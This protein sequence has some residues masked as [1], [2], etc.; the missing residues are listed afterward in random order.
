MFACMFVCLFDI[1][2]SHR[3]GPQIFE[4]GCL[5]WVPG[6]SPECPGGV[7]GGSRGVPGGSRGGPEGSRVRL[8]LLG[9]VLIDFVAVLGP[10]GAGL[11]AWCIVFWYLEG[12]GSSPQASLGTLRR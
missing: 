12:V 8:G 4:F 3:H 2:E 6:G 11:G 5:G 9:A 10:S 7:P 1:P